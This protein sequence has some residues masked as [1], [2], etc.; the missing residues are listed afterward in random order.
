MVS[1]FVGTFF[2]LF[3]AY[4]AVNTSNINKNN[5]P[6]QFDDQLTL[7]I[8]TASLLYIA[9][10]FGTAICIMIFIFGRISGGQ[11]NPAVTLA[12]VLLGKVQPFRGLL[13]VIS[14]LVAGIA[15]AG[16]VMGLVNEGLYVSNTLQPGVTSAKGV[17]IEAFMTAQLVLTVLMMAIE[18]N[19]NV[20]L[21]ALAIGL[22]VF[23]AHIG[24]VYYTG[25]GINPARSLGPNVV[26]GQWNSYDWVYYVGPLIGSI[27][28]SGFFI[29]IKGMRY[30]EVLQQA[31]DDGNMIWRPRRRVTASTRPTMPRTLRS[32][33]NSNTSDS[34][35]REPETKLPV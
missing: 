18:K 12:L 35:S 17:F 27:F 30:E 21:A 3:L 6:A 10:A 28:A 16:L 22:S 11:F 19:D 32:Q 26:S 33:G 4:M 15:A 20:A 14:Q 7:L 24:S 34:T 2:F 5:P 8:N 23:I 9:S 25:T 1:E 13:L 31:D 29:F